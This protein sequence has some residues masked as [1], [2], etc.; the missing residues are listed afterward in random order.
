MFLSEST[1]SLLLHPPSDL[2]FVDEMEV[3]G[4]RARLRLWALD[5]RKPEV[6]PSAPA[7]AAEPTEAPAPG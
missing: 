3:R 2:V 7:P 6:A 1:R 5:V 4:R